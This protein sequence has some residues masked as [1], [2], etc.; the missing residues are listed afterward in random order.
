MRMCLQDSLFIFAAQMK[1]PETDYNV[2]QIRIT[3][4]Q[5]Y[6]ELHYRDELRLT[7]LAA[8]VSMVPTSLCHIFWQQAGTTVSAYISEVRIRHAAEMLRNTSE[9]VKTIAYESGFS[10]LTNFNRQFKKK[11]GCTPSEWRDCHGESAEGTNQ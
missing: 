8:L 9:P 2:N 3:T 4:V 1:K 6:I 10:T 5:D 11:I 7:E